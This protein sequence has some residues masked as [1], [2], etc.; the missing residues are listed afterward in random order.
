MMD[1]CEEDSGVLQSVLPTGGTDQ[2][3]DKGQ[4]TQ[5]QMGDGGNEWDT[6][7]ETDSKLQGPVQW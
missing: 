1:Q 6:D 2:A 5:S 7:L 4:P 3:E